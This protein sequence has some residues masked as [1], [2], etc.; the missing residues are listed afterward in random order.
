MTVQELQQLFYLDRLIRSEQE[1][2][3]TLREAADVKSPAFSTMPKAP[4]A[5]DKIGD[6]V[7]EI[8]DK[9][10]EM[11]E[12]ILKYV[13]MREKLLRFINQVPNSRIK[14]ILILRFVD[15]KSW[16]EVADEIGGKETEDTV[17]QACYR[18]ISSCEPE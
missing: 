13:E 17:K 18:Y 3:Q 14:L 5:K 10:A 9:E 4:G 15:Q 1:R 12:N 6:I 11:R 8:V 7:P 2:L 16:Q